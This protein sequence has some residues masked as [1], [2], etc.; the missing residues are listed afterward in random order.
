[1]Y[2]RC[3]SIKNPIGLHARPATEFTRLAAGFSSS[4]S[5]RRTGGAEVSAKSIILLLS[6]GFT[7]GTQVE[8][9]AEGEDEEQAVEALV[10][11]LNAGCGEE[12]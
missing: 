2:K 1:M 7:Q 3:V 4:I 8:I 10:A 12:S 5:I 11:F 6:Q 9:I